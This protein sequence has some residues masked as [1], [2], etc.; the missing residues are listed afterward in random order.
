[1]KRSLL[2]LAALALALPGSALAKG[3]SEATI[4]GP[5][6]GKGLT[7]RGDGESNGTKLGNIAMQAGFFPAAFGQTPDPMIHGH[8]K[9]VLGPRYTITWVMP[10]PNNDVSR[11]RQDFYPYAKPYAVTYMKPGQTFFDGM[12]THGGWYVS[13]TLRQ[14][15]VAVGLPRTASTASAGRDWTNPSLAAIPGALLLLGAGAVV[16][17]RRR[18]RS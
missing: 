6:L 3:A 17:L 16:V 10:G 8:V 4:Q 2:V 1:M 7:L 5:G 9:A 18:Q 12:K 14:T 13:P 15:L 11:L